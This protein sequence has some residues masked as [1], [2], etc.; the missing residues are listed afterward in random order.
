MS[1]NKEKLTRLALNLLNNIDKLNMLYLTEDFYETIKSNNKLDPDF[2]TMSKEEL[3]GVMVEV[4]NVL[5]RI[6]QMG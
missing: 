2:A 4:R 5:D 3:E 6:N 1:Y